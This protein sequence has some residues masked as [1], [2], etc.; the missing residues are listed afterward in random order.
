MHSIT[1]DIDRV[2]VYLPG[3]HFPIYWYGLL[4]ALGVFLAQKEL[5]FQLKKNSLLNYAQIQNLIFVLIV[6]I[7]IGARVFDIVFY[8]NFKAY[9]SHPLDV[10]NLRQG[11]LSSHGGFFGFLVALKML[12]LKYKTSF[13]SLLSSMSV[14]AGILACFIRLGNFFNQEILGKAYAGWGSV[15]FKSPLDGSKIIPR[16]P[17]VLYEAICY[18]LLAFIFKKIHLPPQKKTAL[19]LVGYFAARGFL[20]IFKDSKL[21]YSWPFDMTIGMA[22]SLPIVFAGLILYFKK[23]S[24][25]TS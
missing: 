14:P 17:V 25:L 10:F 11:G 5:S 15:I 23:Q 4:F 12:S 19:A 8:Q 20:E 16:H 1:W 7:V 21:H 22:L 24:S 18:L 2:L 13:I 6:S 9:L 3:L